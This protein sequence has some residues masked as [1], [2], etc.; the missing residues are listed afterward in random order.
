MGG[1]VGVFVGVGVTVGVLIDS[2]MKLGVGVRCA[3][4]GSVPSIR[5]CDP[6]SIGPQAPKRNEPARAI[7]AMPLC[8][9]MNL[10]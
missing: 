7:V 5:P 9:P 4:P 10:I 6:N 3:A 1:G 2:A 8:L